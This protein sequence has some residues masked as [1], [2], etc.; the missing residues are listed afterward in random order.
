MNPVTLQLIA[1]DVLLITFDFEE[2]RQMNLSFH[3][4]DYK[5]KK[6][7]KLFWDAIADA[8][9]ETGF[10]PRAR[11]FWLSISGEGRRIVVVR[12]EDRAC[13]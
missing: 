2:L 1:D 13:R 9:R 10:N 4:I 6:T 7:R 12:D 3:T 5:N 11:A 8:K